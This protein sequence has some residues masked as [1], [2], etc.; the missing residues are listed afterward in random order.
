MPSLHLLHYL[1]YAAEVEVHIAEFG[2]QYTQLLDYRFGR[3]TPRGHHHQRRRDSH[4]R[5]DYLSCIELLIEFSTLAETGIW[6][7]CLM[8]NHVHLVMVPGHEDGLRAAL[9]SATFKQRS[10]NAAHQGAPGSAA[11]A[12]RDTLEESLPNALS[13]TTAGSGS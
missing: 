10:E 11:Q 2:G 6:A 1:I 3:K 9:G 13:M 8:P 12:S 7:Y 4:R 5:D